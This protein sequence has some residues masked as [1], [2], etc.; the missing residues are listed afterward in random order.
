MQM[1]IEPSSKM[2]SKGYGPSLYLENASPDE[3]AKRPLNKAL[4]LGKSPV[5]LAINFDL[6]EFSEGEHRVG[7]R[8]YFENQVTPELLESYSTLSLWR[9]N[10]KRR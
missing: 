4:P 5:N 8:L 1:E 9:Y 10:V 2:I 3:I 6:S 7:F